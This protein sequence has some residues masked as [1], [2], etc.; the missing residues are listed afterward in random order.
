MYEIDIPVEI[1]VPD[2]SMFSE[3][4]RHFIA[5]VSVEA[6]NATGTLTSVVGGPIEITVYDNDCE[7]HYHDDIFINGVNDSVQSQW[8]ISEQYTQ[9]T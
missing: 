1:Y 6:I 3:E 8:P 4:R 2:N 5:L 9:M 7:S